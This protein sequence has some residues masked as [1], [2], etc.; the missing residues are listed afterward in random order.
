MELWKLILVRYHADDCEITLYKYYITSYN[1][2]KYLLHYCII[3]FRSFSHKNSNFKTPPFSTFKIIDLL[4]FPRRRHP[5]ILFLLSFDVRLLTNDSSTNCRLQLFQR[6][7]LSRYTSIVLL[8]H[9]YKFEKRI[10][11]GEYLGAKISKREREKKGKSRFARV[12]SRAGT[13]GDFWR[14]IKGIEG[15]K[16]IE[17]HERARSICVWTTLGE[18]VPRM[19][20]NTSIPWN[21][22]R[23]ERIEAWTR[24]PS[25][26]RAK[27]SPTKGEK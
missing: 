3:Y 23:S 26:K 10:K 27:I 6:I 15:W 9:G 11:S 18:I 25:N 20:E 8:F 1:W 5:E 2:T 4:P 24:S 22:F 21:R 13:M 7:T 16:A 14:G 19:E 17:F 12:F